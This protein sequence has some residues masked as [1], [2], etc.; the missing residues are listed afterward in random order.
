[1]TWSLPR[2]ATTTN[3]PL[4]IPQRPSTTQDE[5]QQPRHGEYEQLCAEEVGAAER[6]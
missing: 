6:D 1:M 5:Q 3:R 4:T 2:P